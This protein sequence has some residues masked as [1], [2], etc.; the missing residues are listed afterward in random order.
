MQL[1]IQNPINCFGI[2]VHSGNKTQVTLKPANKDV[3]IVYEI[4]GLSPTEWKKILPAI[5]VIGIDRAIGQ[6]NAI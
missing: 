4:T 2:G 1:T 5:N 3:G 6:F